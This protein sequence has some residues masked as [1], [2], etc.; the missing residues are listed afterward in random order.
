MTLIVKAAARHLSLGIAKGGFLT[1]LGP[2]GCGKSTRLRIV[3][4]LEGRT[5]GSVS[6]ESAS[7]IAEQRGLE[8]G[9]TAST[10]SVDGHDVPTLAE[11]MAAP[12]RPS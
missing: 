6:T 2:S 7:A 8:H 1:L 4:G 5:S 10:S 3:A 12:G 11:A 9:P